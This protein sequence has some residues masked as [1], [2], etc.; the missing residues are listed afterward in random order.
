MLPVTRWFIKAGILY[1]VAGLLLLF[2]DS[3]PRYDA[4]V[5]LL[6]VYWHMIVVG[7]ITQLIMGVSI[8]MF[9]RKRRDREKTESV[10]PWF[11]FWLLNI[12]LILR[13]L[14]EPFL[15]IGLHWM[16]TRWFVF[17]SVA[18]QLGACI[19]YVVEIWPRLQTRKQRKQRGR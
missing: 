3:V 8:W 4:G 2:V 12:G 15:E 5:N 17:L 9:P 14:S 18:F 10:L 6:P 16:G 13:F 7:W 11:V 1:L 19:L